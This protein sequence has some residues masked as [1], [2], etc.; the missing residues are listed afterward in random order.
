M[1][2]HGSQYFARRPPSPTLGVKRSK[3]NSF[4]T[5]CH[6]AYQIKGNLECSNMVANICLQTAPTPP[7]R[8]WGGVNRSK[9][10]FFRTWSC[11]ITNYREWSIEH[12]A[13]TYSLLT[14]TLNLWVVL[15]GKKSECGHVAYQIKGK[16]V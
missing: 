10:N 6:V 9:F 13:S 3:M 5:L 14:H 11:C 8:P 16:E 4:R 1:Q 12:R 15:K 2:Q 7:S